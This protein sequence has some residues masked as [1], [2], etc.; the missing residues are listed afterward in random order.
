[1]THL[2]DT[3]R[4]WDYSPDP[5]YDH[6]YG[7]LPANPSGH[8]LVQL[9]LRSS[10]EHIESRRLTYSQGKPRAAATR[11]PNCNLQAIETLSSIDTGRMKL[12]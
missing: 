1:M 6:T 7:S 12:T 2:R 5:C 8:T 11:G 9:Y 4:A 3:D 10:V